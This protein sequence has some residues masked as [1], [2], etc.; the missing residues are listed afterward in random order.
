MGTVE[1]L[2]PGPIAAVKGGV[3]LIVDAPGLALGDPS[4]PCEE[5]TRCGSTTLAAGGVKRETEA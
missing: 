1:V 3:D 5:P 2:A 4:G